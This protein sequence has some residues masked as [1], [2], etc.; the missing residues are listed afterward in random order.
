LH[1]REATVSET[2][3]API[4]LLTQGHAGDRLGARLAPALRE[5]FPDRP[6]LGIGG[7]RIAAAGV[8]VLARTDGISAM[9]YSGLIP[10][11]PATLRAVLA[12]ARG[13]EREVPGCVVA[14]DVWQPL[15]V[16]HRFAPHLKT[17]PH[18]CYLP[19]GP[20]FIGESRVHGAVARAF[21]SIVTP[22]PHQQ[23]LFSE[24]GGRVRPG[25]H[26]G[27]QAMLEETQ[28]LPFEERENLLALLPG[29][30]ALEVRH[31]L[32]VQYEAAR[33]VVARHPQLE[34]VVGCASDEVARQ[35]EREYPGLKTSRNARDLLSRARFGILCSGTAVLEAA[36]LG[37]PGVVTYHGSALQRWEWRTFHIEKLEKLR[38]AGIASRYVA[39]PNILA[40]EAIYPE[41]IDTPAGP[42]AEAALRELAADL[43]EKRAALDRVSASLSWEDAGEVVARCVEEALGL[44]ADHAE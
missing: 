32:A 4:L 31:S 16:L 14:V 21:H 41:Y 8:R 43:R 29:S 24:A 28:P 34:P 5:R 26:A 36:V 11:L 44:P 23:R 12:T 2:K 1:G 17:A 33:Q 22:F 13:T 3:R 40:D 38:E 6:L 7:E 30:R 37:C 20:N 25:G 9:G 42:I 19:P 39:L 27:L 35:V 18:V 15:R 10:Q